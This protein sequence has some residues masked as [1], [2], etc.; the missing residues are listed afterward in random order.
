MT[1]D[2]LHRIHELEALLAQAVGILLQVDS[3]VKALKPPSVPRKKMTKEEV[4]AEFRK[5]RA[6]AAKGL[7]N[8][9][10]G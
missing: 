9:K 6:N 4:I 7:R 5:A 1:T 10:I 2:D 3:A 8:P